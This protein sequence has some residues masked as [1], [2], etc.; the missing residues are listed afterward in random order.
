MCG[1]GEQQ[2]MAELN[3]GNEQ[4]DSWQV[5]RGEPNREKKKKELN[6]PWASE[7]DETMTRRSLT[8]IFGK[9]PIF[10]PWK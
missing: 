7:I 10:I 9:G 2:K 8:S 6:N 5:K 4:P 3:L 1:L